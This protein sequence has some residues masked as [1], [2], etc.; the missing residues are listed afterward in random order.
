MIRNGMPYCWQHDPD[1]VKASP[2]TCQGANHPTI[3][4]PTLS[5]DTAIKLVEAAKDVSDWTI[6][7]RTAPMILATN[8]SEEI[9]AA[10]EEL[11]I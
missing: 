1:R 4:S 10:K 7:G 6:N 9:K 5:R 2:T 8:L 11:G 3:K